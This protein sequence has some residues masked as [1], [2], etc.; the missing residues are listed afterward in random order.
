MVDYEEQEEA[1]EIAMLTRK[2]SACSARSMVDGDD[3]MT[4]NSGGACTK[5]TV[6]N[7]HLVPPRL[8]SFL[9]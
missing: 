4:R 5:G 9:W 8:D 1:Q 3:G 7:Q 2:L 6:N